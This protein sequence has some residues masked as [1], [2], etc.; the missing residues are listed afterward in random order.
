MTARRSEGVDELLALVSE[1]MDIPEAELHEDMELV[2]D[3][4][5][6]SVQVLELV[7]EIEQRWGI[8]IDVGAGCG[9]RRIID[10]AQVAAKSR[11]DGEAALGP[12]S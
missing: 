7:G 12:A 2:A 4:G 5:M 11:D 6:E 1:I 10:L 3:V 8:T 9:L